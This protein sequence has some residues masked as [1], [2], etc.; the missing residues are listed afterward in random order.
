MPKNWLLA[1]CSSS[2]LPPARNVNE[3]PLGY[4]PIY[5]ER[6]MYIFLQMGCFGKVCERSQL[7]N[8][9]RRAGHETAEK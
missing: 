5:R 7:Q 2:T 4:V 9:L 6:N 8:L 3:I 1:P